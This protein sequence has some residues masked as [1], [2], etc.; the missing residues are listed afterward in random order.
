M[1]DIEIHSGIQTA[2]KARKRKV[3]EQKDR[4][5][6][7]RRKICFRYKAVIDNRQ[8][9]MERKTDKVKR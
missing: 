6:K 8:K 1:K 4:R 5:M 9:R 2:K 3:N 7:E